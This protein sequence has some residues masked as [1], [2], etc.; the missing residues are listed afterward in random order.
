MLSLKSLLISI[1]LIITIT[2]SNSY[3]AQ[4]VAD[5][6]AIY[7]IT[8]WKI[9]PGKHVE[10]IKY[11]K[12][13]EEVFEEIKEPPMKWYR[14]ISGDSYDFVSIS[15]PFNYKVEQAMEAAGKKR[16]LPIGYNYTLKLN[17]FADSYTSTIVEGPQSM[18]DLLSQIK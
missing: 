11:M 18:A 2:L 5:P 3:Q 4:A 9:H 1:F 12:E 7:T 10:F 14:K 16:G 17:E 13:W 8:I 15:P 6:S